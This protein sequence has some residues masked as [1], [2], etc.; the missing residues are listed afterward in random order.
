MLPV[1]RGDETYLAPPDDF[2]LALDDE[3]LLVGD[4]AARRLLDS[5]PPLDAGA[6]VSCAT[7]TSRRA[8]SGA[9]STGNRA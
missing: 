8:G 1:V 9:S 4:P 6:R 3:L 7:V 2:P 5:T